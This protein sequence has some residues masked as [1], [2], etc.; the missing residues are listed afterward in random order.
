M[1]TLSLALLTSALLA[2]PAQADWTKMDGQ[3]V[4]SI[5]AK[6][7]LNTAKGEVPSVRALKGK[8]YL[9]EFFSTG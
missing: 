2:L 6:S 5:S 8:V 9:L 7:W 3:P 4:P 1:R